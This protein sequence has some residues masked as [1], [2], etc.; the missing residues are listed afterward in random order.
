MNRKQQIR[1]LARRYADRRWGFSTFMTHGMQKAYRRYAIVRYADGWL[2]A[3][4]ELPQGI[5]EIGPPNAAGE[6]M[7]TVDF[8]RL[9][10]DP[11]YP[12]SELAEKRRLLHERS[13]S[14]PSM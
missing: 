7:L 13:S 12:E 3:H 11:Y 2:T 6:P 1:M 8:D 14:P 4:G 10:S 5:H 9:K